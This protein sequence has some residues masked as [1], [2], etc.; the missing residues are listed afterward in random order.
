MAKLV[1]YTVLRITDIEWDLDNWEEYSTDYPDLPSE[2]DEFDVVA[3]E[4]D[5]NGAI[6]DRLINKLSDAYGWS[7]WG[8][9]YDEICLKN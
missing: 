2:I 7:I 8:L 1:T 5:D 9:S 4:D 6:E 3:Y